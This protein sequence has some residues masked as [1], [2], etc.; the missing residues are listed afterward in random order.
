MKLCIGGITSP[1]ILLG[2]FIGASYLLI[3]AIV[4]S[5]KDVGADFLRGANASMAVLN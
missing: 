1:F 3:A 5:L 2:I 4:I